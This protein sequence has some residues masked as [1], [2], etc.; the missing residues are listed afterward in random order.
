MVSYLK[1]I[2]Y[3]SMC[4]KM[5]FMFFAEKHKTY[6]IK[7]EQLNK[8]GFKK[9]MKHEHC[10]FENCRF[11]RVCNHIH[12]I[13]PGQ[14]Y[15]SEIK[16]ILWVLTMHFAMSYWRLFLQVVHMCCIQV[17]NFILINESMKDEIQNLHIESLSLLKVWWKLCQKLETC[18][19]LFL[20][21]L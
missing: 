8:D 20:Q 18:L 15:L 16:I 4:L 3:F 10:T 14:I 11:S 6:H 13:R 9:F 19:N 5:P 21:N 12:C 7:D 2:E 1:D 17:V